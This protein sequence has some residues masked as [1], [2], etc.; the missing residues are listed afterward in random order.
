MS[1]ARLLLCSQTL[2]LTTI[3]NP[4][5]KM[6]STISV[7]YNT[8]SSTS[9]CNL[10]P[11]M[12]WIQ[13]NISDRKSCFIAHPFPHLLELSDLTRKHNQAKLK[14]TTYLICYWS[15]TQW[16]INMCLLFRKH[17]RLYLENPSNHLEC[18]SIVDPR[19]FW[20]F[21][22]RNSVQRTETELAFI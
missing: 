18:F 4:S 3:W 17:D 21:M 5:H 6:S 16:T 2:H 1:L 11:N 8:V 19:S 9:V 14:E 20:I 7:C 10:I 15:K 22:Y 13:V 12:S